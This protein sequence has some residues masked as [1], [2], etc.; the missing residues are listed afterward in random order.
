MARLEER[1]WPPP[2]DMAGLPRRD[3]RGCHYRAYVPDKL[4]GR[5]FI[6]HGE[7]A[8]D[9]AD[10]ERAIA[11]LESRPS[12]PAD[13]EALARLLLRAESVASSHIEGLQVGVGRLLRADAARERGEDLR[14]VTASE[15]LGN[16]DAMAYAARAAS[17]AH[18]ITPKLLTE[19]HRYLLEHTSLAPHGGK[20]RKVQNWIGGSSYNPCSADFIPPPPEDVRDLLK[21]LCWFCSDDSLPTVAQAALA[22][23]QFETIHP[24]VDGNGRVGRALIH[25]VF[26]RRGLVKQ[27]LLPVSLILATRS[28]DYTAGLS[29]ARYTGSWNSPKAISGINQWVAT[30]AAACTTA[31]TGTAGFEQRIADLRE[32]W[33][34]KLGSVRSDAAVFRLIAVL[35]GMPIVSAETAARAIKRS[36]PATINAIGRLTDAGILRPVHV[37]RQRKQVFETPDIIDAFTSLE[38]QL[39]SP[40]GD[41]KRAPPARPV[42]ARR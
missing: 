33:R 5:R 22:H 16:I 15:I 31:A 40:L 7:E 32:K 19:T 11:A 3:R 9:V 26:R 1:F 20:I 39:A 35:P 37:G 41:T 17:E 14:D 28:L 18:K 34:R 24:F 8:A 13:T 21:D 4:V 42:P 27:T 10:A 30:F 12:V 6:F 36:L 29:A 2:A 25:M 23:A 38:R